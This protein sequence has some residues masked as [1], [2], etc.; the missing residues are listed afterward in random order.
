MPIKNHTQV[1]V[2]E[3][4]AGSENNAPVRFVLETPDGKKGYVDIAW[5]G[6]NSY[7]FVRKDLKTFDTVFTSVTSST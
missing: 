4:V 6:T 5:S 2:V 1:K 7:E 3:V